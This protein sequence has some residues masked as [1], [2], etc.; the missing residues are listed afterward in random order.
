VLKRIQPKS[1]GSSVTGKRKEK[2]AHYIPVSRGYTNYQVL[3]H[4]I[5]RRTTGWMRSGLA[6][7]QKSGRQHCNITNQNPKNWNIKK[8]ELR[9]EK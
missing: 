4:F 7:F 9:I 5:A 1:F 8:K 2:L 6:S 3:I